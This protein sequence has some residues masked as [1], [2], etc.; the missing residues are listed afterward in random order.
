VCVCVSVLRMSA[1]A[2]TGA[3]AADLDERAWATALKVGLAH[4]TPAM[5][6]LAAFISGTAADAPRRAA[7]AAFVDGLAVAVLDL[8]AS[9]KLT[10]AREASV[11]SAANHSKARLWQ[12]A[13]LV[14]PHA[15][16]AAYANVAPALCAALAH[17]RQMGNTRALAQL[18]AAAAFSRFH[19]H[20]VE[21]YVVPALRA[22]DEARYQVRPPAL[23][24]QAVHVGSLSGVASASGVRSDL[25]SCTPP[26]STGLRELGH[27]RGAPAALA[28]AGQRRVRLARRRP[29]PVGT[30]P[31]PRR[32]RASP[33]RSGTA[34]QT[35]K[36]SEERIKKT[37]PSTASMADGHV[38]RL[39][40]SMNGSL[41]T[42]IIV[43]SA[44]AVLHKLLSGSASA[45]APALACARPFAEF[46]RRNPEAVLLRERQARARG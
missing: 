10:A 5:A 46:L 7:A 29:R 32:P 18:A 44:Q 37:M 16:E 11:Q 24:P 25:L 17:P 38:P 12:L 23:C 14:L 34:K 1:C 42:R 13:C 39:S 20:A 31:A 9:P 21:A 30:A 35:S 33:G 15:S 19:A 2:A 4:T 27:R 36:T 41:L 26:R 28:A 43:L 8:A 45:D 6:V 40:L 22:H 3:F